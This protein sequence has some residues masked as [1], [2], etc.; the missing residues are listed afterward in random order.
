MPLAGATAPVTLAAAVVQHVAES[1]SGIV[2]HQSTNPGS[3]IVWGGSPAAVDMRY[4]TTPMGAPGTWLINCANVQVAKYLHLPSHVY[5]GMSDAKLIDAQCGLESMGSTMAAFLAGPNM[6]SGA[7]MF[8]FE[9]CQSIE[10]LVIDAEIIGICKHFTHGIE[11]RETPMGLNIIREI[12]HK[13]DFL[14]SRHTRDWFSRE[15]YLPSKLIDRGS[16]SSWET[17]GGKTIA[18]R[19]HEQAIDLLYAYQD[20]NPLSSEIKSELRHITLTSAR[21]FGMSDLPNLSLV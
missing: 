18:D 14:T 2:I 7:G 4:G 3:P 11:K 17:G 13:G 8:D 12:G 16:Y 9:T 5:M 1:L 6:V 15:L 21:Q 19:A 10:K 20:N